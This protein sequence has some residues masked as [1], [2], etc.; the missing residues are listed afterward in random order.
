[1]PCWELFVILQIE[2]DVQLTNMEARISQPEIPYWNVLQHM[3]D[4]VK[5]DL[6]MMLTQSLKTKKEKPVSAKDFYGIW[7]D[8]GI[9]A[10]QASGELKSMRSFQRPIVEL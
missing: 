1:M 9:S 7:A 3:S 10:E 5:L 2:N 8:D 4:N 6:I